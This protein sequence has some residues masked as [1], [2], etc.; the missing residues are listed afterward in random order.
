MSV[1][2]QPSEFACKAADERGPYCGDCDSCK[3][4]QQAAQGTPEQVRAEMAITC[5][6]R[7]E[8]SASVAVSRMLNANQQIVLQVVNKDEC[9]AFLQQLRDYVRVQV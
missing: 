1:C 4:V 5:L 8:Y 2:W 9:A 7:D 3:T 6:T